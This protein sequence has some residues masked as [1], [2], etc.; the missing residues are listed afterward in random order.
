MNQEE[1]GSDIPKDGI[2][3]ITFGASHHS[4]NEMSDFLDQV[5]RKPGPHFAKLLKFLD[6]QPTEV[7]YALA[8]LM[9][10]GRDR[11]T[12]PVKYWKTLRHSISSKD[13]GLPT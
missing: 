9:H 13:I 3:F 10:S 4:E 5:L 6:A 2:E 12:N 8:A 1:H 7:I 11:K